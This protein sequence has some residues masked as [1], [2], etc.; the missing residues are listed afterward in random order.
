M[1][2]K[3]MN[4]G[5]LEVRYDNCLLEIT[6]EWLTISDIYEDECVIGVFSD[7]ITA[8]VNDWIEEYLEKYSMLLKQAG[9][10]VKYT[11]TVKR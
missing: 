7:L 3:I 4:K 8:Y 5:K 10:D 1:E 2:S 11:N 6:P 9:F